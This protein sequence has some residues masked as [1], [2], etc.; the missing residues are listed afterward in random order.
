MGL[1][2]KYTELVGV[3]NMWADLEVFLQWSLQLM[4]RTGK[5]WSPN[6]GQVLTGVVGYIS[7]CGQGWRGSPKCPAT[8]SDNWGFSP[9]SGCESFKTICT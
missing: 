3:S 9:H 1:M 5:M 7:T 6:S 2:A 4:V 8:A